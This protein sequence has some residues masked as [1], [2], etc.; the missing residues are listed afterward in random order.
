MVTRQKYRMILSIITGIGIIAILLYFSDIKSMVSILRNINPIWIVLGFLVYNINWILRGYRWQIILNSIGHKIGL[1]DSI[2][3]TILGNFINLA[4]PAK[5]GDF[6]RAFVLKRNS[7]VD[8]SK[9]IYS[10]IVDRILDLFGILILAYISFTIISKDLLLPSWT[11]TII[12]N[13]ISVLIIGPII[14]GIISRIKISKVKKF[15]SLIS[16]IENIKAIYKPKKMVELCV[17]SII[18]WI[19][20]ISTMVILLYSINH[21]DNIPL[22]L[23]AVMVANLTKALPLTPGGIGVYEGT[24]ATILMTGGLPYSIGLTMGILEHSIKNIYTIIFGI[25]SLGYNGMSVNNI[26]EFKTKG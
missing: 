22:I 23:F 26:T 14:I 16:L 5:I 1:K 8:I 9:G 11:K 15:S 18:L 4:A 12:D 19:F 20:E 21:L 13:L 2:S 10:V 7:N 24:V 25:P 6:A 3:L 17:L